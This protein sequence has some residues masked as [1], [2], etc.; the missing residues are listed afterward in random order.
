MPKPRS[1]RE[2]SPN[3][4][5]L[6]EMTTTILV[7][8]GASEKNA[9]VVAEHLIESELVGRASHGLRLLPGYV[10]RLIAGQV[11]GIAEPAI[12]HD[13]GGVMRI[14]GNNAFGQVVGDYAAATGVSRARENGIAMI[15]I[16]SSGHFGR[17]AR[18]PEYA[19]RHGVASMHFGH[20]FGSTP[21]VV[22]FGGLDPRL[23]TSPIAFGAPSPDGRHVILDFSV[24]EISANAIKLAFERGERLPR[25]AVVAVDGSLTDDPS[26]FVDGAGALLAF[27][28]FKGY[29]IAVFAEIF[30]GIIAGGGN[31]APGVNAMLSVYFDVAAV[32]GKSRYDK[33]LTKMLEALRSTRSLSGSA[34]SVP[35]DRSRRERRK[36]LA[37]TTLVKSLLPTVLVAAEKTGATPALFDRWPD[38][39]A[40]V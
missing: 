29:G 30:A 27:G 9:A 15:A 2:K 4:A 17:N 13:G 7:T 16:E 28:G 19:A 26:A 33:D 11:D 5:D 3:L 31:S 25:P 23:R 10:D 37:D 14:S 8:A 40:E 38:I 39:S 12:I 36:R 24:A 35:G 32:T 22:P 1:P 34:V 6:A 18:W 20:G 21:T